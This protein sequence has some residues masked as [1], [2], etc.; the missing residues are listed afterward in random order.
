M[1]ATPTEFSFNHAGTAVRLSLPLDD[2]IATVIQTTG[3]FYEL[4]L[5]TALAPLLKSDDL[6]LDVG[7]NIGNHTVFFALIVGCKVISFEPHPDCLVHLEKSVRLNE[8]SERVTIRPVAVGSESGKA[9]IIEPREKNLGM[10]RI[11]QS[12]SGDVRVVRLDDENIGGRVSLLK[13]DTEGMESE[14]ISGSKDIINNDR[15]IIVAEANEIDQ[16]VS[17]LNSL[18]DLQY[19]PLS[20][21]CATPT[22][23]FLPIG[24]DAEKST[25]NT[26]A[27][28]QI[29]SIQ[30][31]IRQ[32]REMERH[33]KIATEKLA[34]RI[35]AIEKKL[36]Q[37]RSIEAVQNHLIARVQELSCEVAGTSPALTD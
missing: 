6:V 27:S 9:T 10:T 1:K 21:Y 8:V 7:A 31:Q 16:F 35:S 20:V 15:P 37:I 29:I 36:V 33:R 17:I 26:A 25:F 19:A 12:S 14:V 32:L 3:E 18:G 30:R 2:H 13:V 22:Y 5:L 4:D 11:S 24:T 34:N 28:R 23:V